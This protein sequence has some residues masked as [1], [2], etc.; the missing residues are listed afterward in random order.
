MVAAQAEQAKADAEAQ[1]NQIAAQ[2]MQ[3]EFAV[4]GQKL[5]LEA[6][7]LSFEQQKLN[8][9]GREQDLKLAEKQATLNLDA[10]KQEFDQMIKANEQQQQ[11]INDAVDNLNTEADT[12]KKLREGMG[13]DTISGP[14][15]IQDFIR[16][17]IR[18]EV[19]QNK[20]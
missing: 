2:R 16:Q 19:A 20:T 8:L 4:E 7:K 6:Q 14:H 18:I 11:S 10:Q 15:G 1:K 9:A 3:G 17:A 5:Q 13:L 12:L